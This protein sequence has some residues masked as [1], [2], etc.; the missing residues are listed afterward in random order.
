MFDGVRRG[1]DPQQG[2][3]PLYLRFVGKVVKQ[4]IATRR[5]DLHVEFADGDTLTVEAVTRP[6]GSGGFE[7]W[8]LEGDYGYS[9]V[10]IAGGGLS[11]AQGPPNP[12][13]LNQ[14]SHP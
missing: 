9:A 1:H 2:P 7:P 6:V 10:S 4:A 3:D 5:G 8:L 11:V 13:G 14:L 12:G